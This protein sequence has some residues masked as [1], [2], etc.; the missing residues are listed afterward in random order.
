MADWKTDKRGLINNHSLD[1]ADNIQT[2]LAYRQK[3][4]QLYYKYVKI[5]GVKWAADL[6]DKSPQI[7]M[8]EAMIKLVKRISYKN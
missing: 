8:T 5:Y 6:V 1:S 7:G 2:A 3:E 4:N